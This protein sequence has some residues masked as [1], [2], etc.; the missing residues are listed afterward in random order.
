[1]SDVQTLILEFGRPFLSWV[2]TG[3]LIGSTVQKAVRKILPLR[4]DDLVLLD[5]LV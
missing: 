5:F 1:M 4:H 2:W 3:S